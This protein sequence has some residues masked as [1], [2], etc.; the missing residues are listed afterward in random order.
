MSPSEMKCKVCGWWPPLVRVRKE[1]TERASESWRWRQLMEHVFEQADV[2]EEDGRA[3]GEHQ[4]L[5]A[6]VMSPR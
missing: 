4:Q 5:E 1:Q 2:E 6:L 3:D